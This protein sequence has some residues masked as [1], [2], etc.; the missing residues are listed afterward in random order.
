VSPVP[1]LRLDRVGNF[2]A[3]FYV[4]APPGYRLGQ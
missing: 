1:A 3:P 4:T 2:N